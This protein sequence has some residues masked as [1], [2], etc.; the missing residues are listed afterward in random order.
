MPPFSQLLTHLQ[1]KLVLARDGPSPTGALDGSPAERWE[2]EE[3]IY[4]EVELPGVTG[5]TIDICIHG[6]RAYIR[7]ERSPA[8]PMSPP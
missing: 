1:D 3:F 4:L 7:M 5:P 2:E 6:S 8:G